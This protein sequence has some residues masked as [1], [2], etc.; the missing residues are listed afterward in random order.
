MWRKMLMTDGALPDSWRVVFQFPSMPFVHAVT[1]V[2][3]AAK[4]AC[5]EVTALNVTEPA[6]WV[7]GVGVTK[8]QCEIQ[9]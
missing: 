4:P 3:G 5:P 2:F 8:L 6:P 9:T 7:I 1:A